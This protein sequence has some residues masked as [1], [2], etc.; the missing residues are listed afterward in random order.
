ML[1]KNII[2]YCHYYK[3]PGKYKN[4]N[5]TILL[6]RGYNKFVTSLKFEATLKRSNFLKIKNKTS[7]WIHKFDRC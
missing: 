5:E 3:I 1:V 7:K 2:K 6:L 4:T